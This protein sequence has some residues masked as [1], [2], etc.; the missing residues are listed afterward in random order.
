MDEDE[1]EEVE[2]ARPSVA[3]PKKT[4][5]TRMKNLEVDR[6]DRINAILV[7]ERNVART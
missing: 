4:M 6:R 5:P 3:T 7:Y 2:V 1:D